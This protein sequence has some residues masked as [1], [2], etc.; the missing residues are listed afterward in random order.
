M[1][2]RWRSFSIISRTSI[3][4]ATTEN[5]HCVRKVVMKSNWPN[6]W[7]S[8][9]LPKLWLPY[10]STFGAIF[11]AFTDRK[12][13]SSFV[14]SSQIMIY[15]FTF[16]DSIFFFYLFSFWK[17]CENEYNA[18]NIIIISATNVSSSNCIDCRHIYPHH[19]Y[20]MDFVPISI[21]LSSHSLHGQS[22]KDVTIRHQSPTKYLSILRLLPEVLTWY[23]P[24]V[25]SVCA[26]NSLSFHVAHSSVSCRNAEAIN[27][28]FASFTHSTRPRH[29]V[30]NRENDG[31][32]QTNARMCLMME[33]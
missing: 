18:F 31:D 25:C 3:G 15:L 20:N 11:G 7:N 32:N 10:L 6:E 1:N 33:E 13:I 8:L 28:I 22:P 23:V 14:P 29:T 17:I 21:N 26:F 4:T 27:L 24:Y 2:W 5:K 30:I 9:F 12:K 16:N 19:S